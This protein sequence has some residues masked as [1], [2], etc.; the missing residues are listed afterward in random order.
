M[1]NGKPQ[2]TFG[3]ADSARPARARSQALRSGNAGG[4]ANFASYLPVS[5]NGAGQQQAG[6]MTAAPAQQGIG[7][8][9][10]SYVPSPRQTR[11]IPTVPQHA[12]GIL[13]TN[14]SIHGNRAGQPHQAAPAGYAPQQAQQAQQASAFAPGTKSRSDARAQAQAQIQTHTQMQTQAQTRAYG[15][16]SY[17]QY[18]YGHGLYG[19]GNTGLSTPGGQRRSSKPSPRVSGQP[20]T[21]RSGIGM[22]DTRR[23]GA[24]NSTLSQRGASAYASPT[25][26]AAQAQSLG[27]NYVPPAMQNAGGHARDFSRDYYS[28]FG[29]GQY[30]SQNPNSFVAAGFSGRNAEQALRTLGYDPIEAPSVQT[31]ARL[32][33]PVQQGAGLEAYGGAHSVHFT[34]G[35]E[36]ARLAVQTAGHRKDGR[37]AQGGSDPAAA[38]RGMEASPVGS[39]RASGNETLMGTIYATTDRTLGSLAAKFESG[40]E[41]IAAIGYDSKGGTS[42]GKYQIASKPGTMSTF[43]S[44]LQEHA[45]D[46]ALR[47]NGAGPANTG[48][49]NGRMPAEWRKIAADEPARFEALQSDF[50]HSSHFQP[51]LRGIAEQTGLVF[52]GMPLALQEVLF[53]T[54]VQH[55]PSGAVRIFNQALRGV[56]VSKLQQA[57][58]G[59]TESFLRTG[60]QLIQKVYSLRA[61]QFASSTSKVQAA[62]RSRLSQEMRE[63]LGML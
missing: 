10:N 53:S 30:T 54:A 27:M 43:I 48:G 63:A 37:Q 24:G 45:P 57:D 7:L 1:V 18:P 51:A 62:V 17:G 13:G 3:S 6:R 40:S 41:G 38:R 56:D 15:Q 26:N 21:G 25:A 5:Q 29:I 9:M 2:L 50:I 28:A 61:T 12:Q 52:T 20:I 35:D 60:R 16:N 19:Q 32:L 31:R 47:L 49:R 44:Y 23:S 36:G 46:L 11:P 34:R 58:N 39:A 4:G 42:Y 14:A 59:R 55:G 33:D 8:P 22:V